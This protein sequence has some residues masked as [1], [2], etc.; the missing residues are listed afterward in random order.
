L[1]AIALVLG[2]LPGGDG[3]AAPA[4]GKDVMT[5]LDTEDAVARQAAMAEI[6]AARDE[7]DRQVAAILERRVEAV[8]RQG[9]VKDCMLLLGKLHATAY[10]PLLVKHLTFQSFYKNTKR[11][12]T[13]QDLHPAVPALI[14]MGTPAIKPVLAR[15]EAEDDA[16]LQRLGAAVLRGVLGQAW[17][18][19]IVE[20]AQRSASDPVRARLTQVLELLRAP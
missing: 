12:Q 4:K 14:D 2:L 1:V 3:V 13:L 16:N 15:L 5:E 19:L 18:I 17:A 11:P 6:L 20:D 10:V 7:A 8:D 9:T